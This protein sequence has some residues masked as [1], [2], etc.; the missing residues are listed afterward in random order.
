MA[1]IK[2]D[3]TGD[4]SGFLNVMSQV[5]SSVQRT[6]KTIEELGKSFNVDGI[7]NQMVALNKVIRDN[8][9]VIAKSKDNIARWMAD[10]VE[11]LKG[12]DKGLFDTIQKDIS[13]EIVKVRELTEETKQYQSVLMTLQGIDGSLSIGETAP[14]L[15]NSEE[16]FRHVEEL[17]DGIEQLK[18]TIAGFDGS[19]ADL[20]GLRSQLSG[21]KSELRECEL[22]AAKNAAALG[23]GGKQ[24]AE[25]STKFYRL[26]AAVD[27][28]RSS[29]T[30][31]ANRMNEAASALE[32]AKLGGNTEEIDNATIM[33]DQLAESLQGAKMHLINL[34]QEQEAAKRGFSGDPTQGIRTQLRVLTQQ[35]A[36]LTLQYRS[37]SDEEKNSATGRDMQA[38]LEALISK[39][40]DLRDAMDDVN[41]AIQ[42]TASDTKN[43]D[44]LAGG[45]NVVTSAFGG[46]TGAAAMFGVKQEELMDIQAKLQAS[47]AISNALSVIQNNLQ[48]ESA[49]MLGIANVQR[50]ASAIAIGLET[51]AKGKGTIATVAATAAQAAFNAVAK[52]NPYVLLASAVASVVGAFA[53]FA[54]GSKK[55]AEA[56]KKLQEEK[57]RHAKELDELKRKEEEHANM[58]GGK[59]SSSL[60]ELMYTYK[61]LQNEYSNLKSKHEKTQWIKDNA[62]EFKK[63]G[64]SVNTVD[65]AEKVLVDNTEIMVEAFKYRAQAAAAAAE[66]MNAYTEAAKLEFEKEEHIKKVS[67]QWKDGDKYNGD[68]TRY[69]LQEGKDFNWDRKGDGAILTAAGAAKANAEAAKLSAET[70]GYDKKIA[71]LNE[72]AEKWIKKQQEAEEKI[73]DLLDGAK[74]LQTKNDVKTTKDTKDDELSKLEENQRK[75]AE[76]LKQVE[77]ERS[78]A[79]KD[80]EFSTRQAEIDAMDDGMEKSLAQITLNFQKQEEAIKRGYED[81]KQK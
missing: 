50:K 77:T 17:R 45:I 55:A 43:F 58:I 37:L 24:A 21:M 28:Q 12:N 71:K 4:N 35:I 6:S 1:S 73:N 23:E 29:V 25:A 8:E 16:E 20:Q 48:K 13:E 27:E 67:K 79:V 65:E 74:I 33:Y 41:R 2:F 75:Y 54:S 72:E 7:E 64:V 39:A 62:S 63:L 34:E 32:K 44:A 38:K 59:Y 78:R 15:F 80:M 56:E 31:L 22:S 36:E 30:D 69:G 47:L 18:L 14:M 19:E 57:E 49:L 11:A 53:L 26:S 66:A 76:K 40:G 10:A 42:A 51:A 70:M 61:K 46:V 52:A 60:S 81:L 3:I 68:I 9:D 5:Q